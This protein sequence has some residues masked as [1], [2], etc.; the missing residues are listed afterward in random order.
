MYPGTIY[1]LLTSVLKLTRFV[2]KYM[3]LTCSELVHGKCTYIC[4]SVPLMLPSTKIH[5]RT[6]V[7]RSIP[8]SYL[9]KSFVYAFSKYL[10]R[11]VC[12]NKCGITIQMQDYQ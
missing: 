2:K 9:V 10:K 4:R 11:P 7:H 6:Y 12:V 3:S 1:I 5:I 8:V